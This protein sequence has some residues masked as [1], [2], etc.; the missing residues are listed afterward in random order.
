MIQFKKSEK[1]KETSA[2]WKGERLD[3]VVRAIAQR[4]KTSYDRAHEIVAPYRKDG[5]KCRNVSQ[6]LI[7]LGLEVK[8]CGGVTLS[9]FIKNHQVG[10]Y[11][12]VK[13]GHA[14]CVDQGIVID[15]RPI[16]GGA[17]VLI[18]A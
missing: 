12:V 1:T 14:F 16:G 9:E 4:I 7:K 2:I 10:C 13:R 8:N 11:I 3:C 6:L 5:H 18:Y 17:R 15:D